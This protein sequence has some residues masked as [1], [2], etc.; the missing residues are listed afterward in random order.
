ME[1]QEHILVVDDEAA[2]RN[3]VRTQLNKLGYLVSVAGNVTEALSLIKQQTFA[4]IISDLNLDKQSG[5]D[6]LTELK[7]H[8]PTT[9]FILITGFATKENAVEALRQGA[10]DFIEKP[11]NSHELK[12]SLQRAL[13]YRRFKL[14]KQQLVES[15]QENNTKLTAT[16]K[17][18]NKLAH[19][20]PL[21]DLLP[22]E[23]IDIAGQDLNLT[24][25]ITVPEN[26]SDCLKT[27]IPEALTNTWWTQKLTEA[28]LTETDLRNLTNRAIHISQSF[29]FSPD[30]MPYP[31]PL[32]INP[33][34]LASLDMPLATVLAIP[35]QARGG[36]TFGIMWVDYPLAPLPPVDDVQR[37]EIF[38]NQ[39]TAT[40]ENTKLFTG[41]LNQLRV[42]NTLVQAGQRIATLLDHQ[43]VA[44]TV[45]DAVKKIIP[46]MN[47]AMIYYRPGRDAE[48][49]LVGLT[50]TGQLTMT[51][52]LDPAMVEQVLAT[53]QTVYHPFWQPHPTTPP[54]SLIIEPLSISAVPLGVLAVI[55]HQSDV[56]SQDNHQILTMLANQAAIALQNATLYAEAQRV[57]EIEALYEAGKA[58]DSTLNLQETLTTTMAVSRSLTGASVSNVYLYSADNRR[59]DSVVTLSDDLPLTDID[60]RQAATIARS[61]IKNHQPELV[62]APDAASAHGLTHIINAW[63][64]VPLSNANAPVG[65]LELGSEQ[66]GIFNQNDIRLMQIVASHA[67]AAVE[68]SRLYEEVQHRLQQTEALNTISQSISTTLQLEQVLHMVVQSA[69]KTIPVATQSALYL[70]DQHN[71]IIEPEAQTTHGIPL[72]SELMTTRKETVEQA[73]LT[74]STV[75]VTRTTSA[76]GTWS[77]LVVPLRTGGA[78]SGAI[79]VVSPRPEA[80][81]PSDE[82]L[83][84]AFASHASIAIQNANLFRDL[85][86]AYLD[87]S[88]KQ[89]E[90]LR[91]HST[92]QAL[93]D[94]ITDGL[95]I[96]N[97]T[98]QI[99]AVNQSEA[100]RL[101]STPEVLLG[102]NCDETLWGEAAPALS[103]RVL[104]TLST[105]QEG[106]WDSQ[107]DPDN[108]AVFT[109][110]DV[111]TYPIIGSSGQA[112]Q[113][114]IFAQDVSEK[115]RL[116][117]SLFRSANMAAVGQLASSVAHQI[118]NPLTVI[119]AN[120]QI[121]EMDADPHSPDYGMI[122]HIEESGTHIRKIVQNL[123][124]FSTQDSYEWFDT[125]VEETINDALML[126]THS[127]RKSDIAIQKH[128]EAMPPIVASASH[129]KLLW[130]NLLLNARD[131]IAETENKGGQVEIIA[132]P[133]GGKAIQVQLIDNGI[134]VPE[135]H[136]DRLFHPFFTTKSSGKNLGLGLFTCG[137]I[138]EV[139]QGRIE[140][141]NN[142]A[143]PGAMVTVTLPLDA[144]NE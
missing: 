83:L 143:G 34:A 117:A 4:L 76:H 103:Q 81:H 47:L 38:A 40:I 42:R 113:V 73:I 138:V 141:S 16:L 2:M 110:R 56:F 66:P 96:T 139:H 13:N 91:S 111:Y 79:S 22:N 20:S 26:D 24:V 14:E 75:R 137:A 63:L 52:P 33:E 43:E 128:I 68:K 45:L 78:V 122:Q 23:I 99:V 88:Q 125:D 7:E 97:Q 106:V 82:T 80:F 77:L 51:S 31:F 35:M 74:N 37:L 93:F 17:A 135:Q 90:I 5:F 53:R 86:S 18:S 8:S 39:I 15:L 140:L 10:F 70:L 87:L 44:H 62:I 142:P 46:R 71:E 136:R 114:I 72:P 9:E 1:I 120:S 101:N 126:V 123:L 132:Q 94:G 133:V 95:Y 119:I 25:A 28:S 54:Q 48:L 55:S 3:L 65:V 36:K 109:E 30:N 27:I 124:D 107:T 130:M 144:G 11:V 92:L 50:H 104:K 102:R 6:I 41:Q 29:V 129:L 32:D 105:G 98:L 57:D 89:E 69:V 21:P 64:A 100:R 61:V 84:N 134:G 112:S 85:S 118:N 60:R 115:R 19:L 58:I 127:L 49:T 121:M 116:Q 131:A 67:A 59:I 108:R 12:H